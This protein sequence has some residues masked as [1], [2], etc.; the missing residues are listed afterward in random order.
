M[1]Y[2]LN[3]FCWPG[4]LFCALILLFSEGN[5]RA[6]PPAA[7]AGPASA[8]LRSLSGQ[9]ENFEVILKFPSFKIGS[10]VL[11]TAY[12][13]DSVT[14]EPIKGA[15]LSGGMSSG[16]DSI[17]VAFKQTPESTPGA[18][19]GQVR[20]LSEKPYS[21]LFDISLGEKTDLVAIDGFKAG[22]VSG[23]APAQASLE[24]KETGDGINLTPAEIAVFI[25][26]FVVLQVAI[27]LFV[28][29]RYPSN[30]SAKDPR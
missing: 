4:L 10:D 7:P 23:G 24:H 18:Y 12:V 1:K 2:F 17:T 16:S 5:V 26:A 8:A 30:A 22:E 20:V 19:A 13:L 11:L 15:A 9:G 25:A 3:L 14:N 28:R 6:N 29:K 27:I 21:W